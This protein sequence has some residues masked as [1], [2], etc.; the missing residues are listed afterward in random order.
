MY[1]N[2]VGSDK[3]GFMFGFE[4]FKYGFGWVWEKKSNQLAQVQTGFGQ[5]TTKRPSIATQIIVSEPE[6]RK[7]DPWPKNRQRRKSLA[8]LPRP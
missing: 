1:H 6:E 2:R 3:F 4:F 8:D 7:K 5:T